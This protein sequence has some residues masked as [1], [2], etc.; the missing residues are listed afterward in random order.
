MDTP[1]FSGTWTASAL[2]LYKCPRYTKDNPYSSMTSSSP[3]VVATSGQV[4]PKRPNGI[5]V[6]GSDQNLFS[7]AV[8]SDQRT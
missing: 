6:E 8:I 1:R 3:A 2:G 7:H 5:L 4:F